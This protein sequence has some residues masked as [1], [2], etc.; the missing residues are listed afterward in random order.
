[1]S[2]LGLLLLSTHSLHISLLH[3]TWSQLYRSNAEGTSVGS[4]SL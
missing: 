2:P 4:A 1:L 3:F